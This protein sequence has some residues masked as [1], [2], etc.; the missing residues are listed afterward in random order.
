M[1][2]DEI[3]KFYINPLIVKDKK[4]LLAKKDSNVQFGNQI[5]V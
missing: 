5:H 2:Q 3:T 4:I 1:F